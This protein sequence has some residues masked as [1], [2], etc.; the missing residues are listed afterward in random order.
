[1]NIKWV[2]IMKLHKIMNNK[3]NSK[4]IKNNKKESL[5]KI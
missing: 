1:M 5:I 4:I 2:F 3:K